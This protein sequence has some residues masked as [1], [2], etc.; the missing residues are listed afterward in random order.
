MDDF[1]H[2]KRRYNKKDLALKIKKANLKIIYM[3]SFVFTL[4]PLMLA[5]RIYSNL[6]T[7][8]INSKEFN[9]IVKFNPLVNS[10][11]AVC[12]RIDEWLIKKRVPLP[13][14]GSLIAIAIKI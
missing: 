11:L 13:W 10:I 5:S 9:S 8:K 4:F 1:V 7:S 14:G 2:H 3:S 6:N 12:M